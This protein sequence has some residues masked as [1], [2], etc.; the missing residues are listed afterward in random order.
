MFFFHSCRQYTGRVTRSYLKRGPPGAKHIFFCSKSFCV[1]LI[2]LECCRRGTGQT[3][4]KTNRDKKDYGHRA[5]VIGS[6]AMENVWEYLY[7]PCYHLVFVCIPSWLPTLTQGEWITWNNIRTQT[8]VM[9]NAGPLL[10]QTFLPA[11]HTLFSQW[12]KRPVK[13]ASKPVK[14]KPREVCM[15]Q[16]N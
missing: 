2:S 12:L 8:S 7:F 10:G 13:L 5:F 4:L 11:L 3:R 16:F 14:P 1:F 15:L 9:T 6:G